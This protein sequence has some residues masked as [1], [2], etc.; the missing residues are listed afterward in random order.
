MCQNCLPLRGGRCENADVNVTDG[1][2]GDDAEI[3]DMVVDSVRGA[4]GNRGQCVNADLNVSG[5]ARD[6]D[7]GGGD[8]RAAGIVGVAASGRDGSSRRDGEI[9]GAGMIDSNGPSLHIVHKAVNTMN[10][11]YWETITTFLK[12]NL[13]HLTLC[14]VR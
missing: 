9:G 3:V 2:D 11:G 4:D 12:Q 14:G 10:V 1:D 7:G 8:V 6:G 5:N 13:L